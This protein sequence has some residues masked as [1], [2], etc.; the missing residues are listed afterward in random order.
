MSSVGGSPKTGISRVHSRTHSRAGSMGSVESLSLGNSFGY[1]VGF[2][3][4][5][6]SMPG[7]PRQSFQQKAPKKMEECI[8]LQEASMKIYIPRDP[9]HFIS[10]ETL[11]IKQ[12]ND[13]FF[14]TKNS[15]E[16]GIQGELLRFYLI[17]SS[18]EPKQLSDE[19][20]KKM[21]EMEGK[22]NIEEEDTNIK[23]T[24]D[25]EEENFYNCFANCELDIDFVEP[26]DF[27][28]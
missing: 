2:I 24:N 3:S 16:Y 5:P 9:E 27:F 26:G 10:L 8:P 25:P 7:T 13:V 19:E 22:E 28:S 1:D 20:I 6:P 18:N 12:L 14:N 4:L 21:E 11:D 17:I 15:R 23:S